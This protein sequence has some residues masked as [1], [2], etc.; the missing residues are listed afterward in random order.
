[1]WSTGLMDTTTQMY[2][3]SV[4]AD[5]RQRLEKQL[6][7]VAG[8]DSAVDVQ[9]HVAEGL[10]IADTAILDFI[11]RR[12][13]DLLV[14]GTM[15]RSGIP[16]VFIGNTAERLVTHLSCSLLAVK[17]ADFVSPIHL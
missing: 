17:P 5:A 3:E 16:G 15:A 11:G 6:A 10:S 7:G 9:L 4:N 2:H 13:I 8:D 14:M 12:H 1:L